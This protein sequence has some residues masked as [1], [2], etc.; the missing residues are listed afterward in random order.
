MQRRKPGHAVERAPQRLAIDGD[1]ALAAF[2]ELAHE[3]EKAG[4]ELRRVEQA[5]HPREGVMAGNAVLQPQELAQERLL[6]ASKHG[7]V[8]AVLAS[9]QDRAQ[10]NQQDLVQVV[11]LG[12]ARARILQ[13]RKNR[14][15]SLQSTV[16][17]PQPVLPVE[18]AS[19][20]CASPNSQM[21]FPWFTLVP[22][23]TLRN[24]REMFEGCLSGGACT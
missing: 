20:P 10:R 1:N 7:H 22:D 15:K 4:M 11:T 19:P 8:G 18:S 2:G 3:G 21:R 5:K 9:A 13:I 16:L 24:Y 23:V 12:I 14:P 6:G 17:P